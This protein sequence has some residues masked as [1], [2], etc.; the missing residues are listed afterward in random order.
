MKVGLETRQPAS[1]RQLQFHIIPVL[2]GL[3]MG[4][5]GF[6]GAAQNFSLKIEFRLV[7]GASE[8][9]LRVAIRPLNDA[10]LM[11]ADRRYRAGLSR[12]RVKEQTLASIGKSEGNGL[13]SFGKLGVRKR[14]TRALRF[15]L[16]LR[17]GVAS[18]TR[19]N[20]DA[21]RCGGAF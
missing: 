9:R 18:A 4:E 13:S 2:R 17:F 8:G 19:Q 1:S 20:R 12:K 21:K 14:E 15:G 6:G 11:G 5:R 7:A 16:Q 10:A 3:K